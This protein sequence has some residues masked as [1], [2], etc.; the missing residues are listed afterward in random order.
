MAD[1]LKSMDSQ[2]N[3]TFDKQD[4]S[5]AGI[6][7]AS[8]K[9]ELKKLTKGS[10]AL[11]KPLSAVK[12]Q[13]LE[14]T[15][16][17][18]KNKKETAKWIPQIKLNRYF[19]FITFSNNFL[20]RQAD[21]VDYTKE[22]NRTKG[23]TIASMAANFEAKDDTEKEIEKALI[24][25][26]LATDKQVMEKEK[27]NLWKLEPQ[28]M[29]NRIKQMS[30]LKFMLFRQEI[31]NKRIKKIKSKLYHK[32]KRKAREKDEQKLLQELEQVDPQ[33][34]KEYQ[35]K[36]EQKRLE[37]R[38]RYGFIIFTFLLYSSHF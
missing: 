21:T 5:K 37:E 6:S 10:P 34:A 19:H 4:T 2:N 11:Q 33:A 32:I 18:D 30:K 27:Q 26:G 24:N 29:Q 7:S 28:E 31:K 25:D 8:L 13:R 36:M 1:F 22:E 16:N 38:I 9:K 14:R 3:V 17:Y 15:V 23:A 12:Q 20:Y 35:E